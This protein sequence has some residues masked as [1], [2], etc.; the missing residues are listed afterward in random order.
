MSYTAADQ[1][2]VCQAIIAT[3]GVDEE[4]KLAVIGAVL[5]GPDATIGGMR[6]DYQWFEAIAA[7]NADS[8]AATGPESFSA[9]V[10]GT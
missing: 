8:P 3:D 6:V 10:D 4:T 7:L 1:V 9:N 2:S 5:N